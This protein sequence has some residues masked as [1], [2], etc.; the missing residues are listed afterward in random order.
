LRRSAATGTSEFHLGGGCPAH[1]A[2]CPRSDLTRSASL[3]TPPTTGSATR[4]SGSSLRAS[5]S[6]QRTSQPTRCDHVIFSEHV[7]IYASL[8]R[9]S[10]ADTSRSSP[11]T[12]RSTARYLVI[13]GVHVT[14][15]GRLLREAPADTSGRTWLYFPMYTS[16]LPEVHDV[17]PVV[18]A[19]SSRRER[20]RSRGTEAY[21]SW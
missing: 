9:D 21:S 11:S 16:V 18:H 19:S 14:I 10:G 13:F 4:T 20:L 2:G 3:S 1:K 15:N 8:H 5:Q 6:N 17:G 7:R 12:F